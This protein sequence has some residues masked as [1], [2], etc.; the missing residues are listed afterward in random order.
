MTLTNY[1]TQS[2]VCALLFT[3]FGAALVGR[4]PPPLVTGIAPALF[5]CQVV[6][7]RRWPFSTHGPATALIEYG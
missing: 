1:L 2:L 5:A 3:G 4:V 6:A 7:C